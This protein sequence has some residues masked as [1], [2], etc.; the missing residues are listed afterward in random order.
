MCPVDTPRRSLELFLLSCPLPTSR[1]EAPSSEGCCSA[2]NFST[3]KAKHVNPFICRST[4]SSFRVQAFTSSHCSCVA[5]SQS[6]LICSTSCVN[7]WYYLASILD[8][9][10]VSSWG[11]LLPVAG[12]VLCGFII[13]SSPVVRS[14]NAFAVLSSVELNR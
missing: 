9:S 14:D 3:C 7:A 2:R 4:C 1:A 13:C 11:W 10:N 5:R 12:V 6:S 8:S